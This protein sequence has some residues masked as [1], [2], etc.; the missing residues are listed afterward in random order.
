MFCTGHVLRVT[1]PIA[2]GEMLV[3]AL[4]ES[5]SSENHCMSSPGVMSSGDPT[6][7]KSTAQTSNTGV[8]LGTGSIG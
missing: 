6:L 4:G 5:F 7:R 2:D 1:P 3:L 8:S